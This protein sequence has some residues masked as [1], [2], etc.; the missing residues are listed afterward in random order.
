MKKIATKAVA[1]FF[2]LLF[3]MSGFA[4]IGAAAA[5]D[6]A[7]ETAKPQ[8]KI[9]SESLTVVKGKT[10]QLTATVSNAE[11]YPAVI[12]SSSD[13]SVAT[14]DGN[15]AVKG[16]NIG[17]SIITASAAVNGETISDSFV[18]NVTT[19]SHFIKNY[20]EDQ[21]VLGYQ[22]SYIDDYYYTNDKDCWQDEFGFGQVYDLVAP[23]VLLEYDYVRVFFT[24][25]NKDWMI[26]LWKGQ[27]GMLFYGSEMGVYNKE[28]TGEE[29][30]V[31]T[32]YNCP[33][34]EDWLNM[35]MTLYHEDISGN[36]V[37]EL[38]REY[39]KY[40]WCTG[41]KGGHLRQ[42]EPADE[43]RMVSRLTLKD[44]EMTKLFA[45]GLKECGFVEVNSKADV[46]IDQFYVE[47][48]DV[49]LKWQDISEA[50]NT[51]PIKVVGGAMTTWSLLTVLWPMLPVIIPM[52]SMFGLAMLFLSLVI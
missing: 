48:N 29:D 31:A 52:L 8:I 15:G 1:V 10:V 17:K 24:Y 4:A 41:F 19:S 50:E 43:L 51:M 13:T 9:T 20:L 27:Y 37:R 3:V 40:W 32:F 5:N 36:Y 12:W 25:E 44:E 16:I 34:E 23:Y 2:V 28:H 18:I 46:A 30:T 47:G 14:V 35:E 39:D 21:Q 26:Q 11:P 49:Y 7:D 42:E 38:T 6:T 22:Y 33:A 45:E